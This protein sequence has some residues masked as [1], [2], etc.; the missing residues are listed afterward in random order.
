MVFDL[1]IRKVAEAC[2]F[3][4][5]SGDSFEVFGC[6][7]GLLQQAPLE[8]LFTLLDQLNDPGVLLL[9]I[10]VAVVVRWLFVSYFLQNGRKVEVV[11]FCH[12]EVYVFEE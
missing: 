8:E 7:I 12:F 6:V 2:Y 11:M 9:S 5:K 1:A 4:R 3:E 10:L